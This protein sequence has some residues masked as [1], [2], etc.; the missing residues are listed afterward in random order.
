MLISALRPDRVPRSGFIRI[1]FLFP[2]EKVSHCV[3]MGS[4]LI[5]ALITLAGVDFYRHRICAFFHSRCC[6]CSPTFFPGTVW[7]ARVIGNFLSNGCAHNHTY[8][9]CSLYFH[10][11]KTPAGLRQRNDAVDHC[12]SDSGQTDPRDE[13]PRGGDQQTIARSGKSEIGW[14]FHPRRQ[15]NLN[16]SIKLYIFMK[17]FV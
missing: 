11:T 3:L 4:P 7:L 1:H 12:G 2:S 10:R 6:C 5:N 13:D 15:R 17:I 9:G 16:L 8:P 14:V